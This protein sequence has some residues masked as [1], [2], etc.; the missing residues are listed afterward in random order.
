MLEIKYP[1]IQGAYGTFGT[2]EFAVPVSEAG[3]LGMITA[4]GFG[5]PEAFREELK[6]AKSMTDKPLAVNLTIMGCPEIEGMRDVIIE[7]GGVVAVE[8][9]P[10]RADFLGKPLQE[11][12][13]KW[14]HKI[15]SVKHAMAAER[16]GADAVVIVGL[17]GAGF[18]AMD[19]V[20]TMINIPWAVREIKIP[21]I[22]A[23]GIGDARGFMAALMMGAEAVYMGTAFMPTKECPI[24]D[25]Y[26]KFLADADPT[27]Q[28]IRSKCL[29][30]PNMDE[31]S[32]VL[33]QRD[34]MPEH[35][36]LWKL[37]QVMVG[38]TAKD[39]PADMAAQGL[40]AEVLR[41]VPGSLAVGVLN[42]IPT[43]KE[44]ID[45]MISEAEEL[46][47]RWSV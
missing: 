12:G 25:K 43:I 3:G 28:T 36:W 24:S 17:E 31:L 6:K 37:E 42:E 46:R 18:K 5:T 41:A 27:N 19:Q 10:M 33:A 44:F 1:I 26:K 22:A 35:E 15:G 38:S 14:I 8:T 29:T 21:V 11:H 47:R 34:E 30:P 40:E 16:Q 13:I 39:L 7:E 23:G 32:K 9:A 4:G 20:T 2:A 45:T